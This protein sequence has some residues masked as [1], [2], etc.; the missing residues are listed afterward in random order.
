MPDHTMSMPALIWH[1]RSTAEMAGG[2]MPRLPDGLVYGWT[3][4]DGRVYAGE[5]YPVPRSRFALDTQNCAAILIAR[6]EPCL[7]DVE[8]A[9]RA[10]GLHRNPGGCGPFDSPT[11][12]PIDERDQLSARDGT[13]PL[14][15]DFAEQCRSEAK[16]MLAALNGSRTETD[17]DD[18]TASLSEFADQIDRFGYMQALSG[19]AAT[20]RSAVRA[21][22][23][24][25]S[26]VEWHH[27]TTRPEEMRRIVMLMSDGSGATLC[28]WTGETLF[29]QDGDERPW[30]DV[31]TQWAYLPKGFELWCENVEDSPMTFP[32]KG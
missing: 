4:V 20:L 15:W 2:K 14:T 5:G 32:K 1:N 17:V 28:F 21:I 25:G 9:A 6:T 22:V 18:L 7:S 11:R 26:N 3:S 27:Q 10:L 31:D 8:V 12:W 13:V 16:V 30:P 29:D 23:T 24:A 19:H